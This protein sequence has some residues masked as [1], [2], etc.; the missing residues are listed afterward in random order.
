[1][2]E[3]TSSAIQVGR[4]FGD[5]IEVLSGMKAG[6]RAIV[7]PNDSVQEGARVQPVA[8]AQ[9]KKSKH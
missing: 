5:S 8:G 1:M 9:P 3:C 6:D 7:N 2:I 4:D